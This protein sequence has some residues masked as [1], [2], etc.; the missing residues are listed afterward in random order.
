MSR[1]FHSSPARSRSVT[2]QSIEPWPASPQVTAGADPGSM[3]SG[4]RR[5]SAQSGKHA[6]DSAAFAPQG[7]LR[8]KL[9]VSPSCSS[10]VFAPVRVVHSASS[11]T[12]ATCRDGPG[13][14]GTSAH[15]DVPASARHGGEHHRCR[16]TMQYPVGYSQSMTVGAARTGQARSRVESAGLATPELAARAGTSRPTLSAY[17]HG[18]KSPTLASVERLDDSA[19]FELTVEPRVTSHRGSPAARPPDLRCRSAMAPP[20]QAGAGQR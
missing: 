15:R 4:G 11:T 14:D 13:S 10:L 20:D 12:I 7:R 3:A 2:S 17:E 6:G 8:V 16:A 19:D 18:R 1:P 5:A 9:R